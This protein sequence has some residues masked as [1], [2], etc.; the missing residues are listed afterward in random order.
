VKILACPSFATVE[1]S[2][3]WLEAR[4]CTRITL[5]RGPDGLVRGNGVLP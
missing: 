1:E 3:D 4:G 2:I 5:W